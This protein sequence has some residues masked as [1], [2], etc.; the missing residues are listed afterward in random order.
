MEINPYGVHTRLST[1]WSCNVFA[2]DHG[3]QV[4]CLVYNQAVPDGLRSEP[5]TLYVT[6]MPSKYAIHF[7]AH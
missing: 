2:N 7:F 5:R 3:A 1:Y 6:G 4:S